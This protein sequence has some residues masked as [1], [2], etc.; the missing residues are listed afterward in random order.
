MANNASNPVSYEELEYVWTEWHKA[1]GKPI[2]QNYTDFIGLSDEAAILN[3]ILHN[4]SYLK[5][6]TTFFL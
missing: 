6:L 4:N 1:A 3:G 5:L 2:K